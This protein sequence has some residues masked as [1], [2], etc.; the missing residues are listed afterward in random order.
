VR[1]RVDTDMPYKCTWC[2][3]R[4]DSEVCPDCGPDLVFRI[5]SEHK[6]EWSRKDINTHKCKVCDLEW[7]WREDPEPDIGD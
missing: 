3:K 1:L 7:K 6:H 5:D 2:M 4:I